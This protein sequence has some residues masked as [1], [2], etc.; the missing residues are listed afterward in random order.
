LYDDT[1]VGGRSAMTKYRAIEERVLLSAVA[2]WKVI[3]E[4][5]SD[6][7]PPLARVLRRARVA[8]EGLSPPP[9]KKETDSDGS[10][11]SHPWTPSTLKHGRQRRGSP[12]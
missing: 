2:L 11:E 7:N 5:L 6:V 3:V 4:V 12:T 1:E 9:S 8:Y 10:R